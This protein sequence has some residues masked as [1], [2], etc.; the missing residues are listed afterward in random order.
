MDDWKLVEG[1]RFDG[2]FRLGKT[3]WRV[4]TNS[5]NRRHGQGTFAPAG[6]ANFGN[7]LS[8]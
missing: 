7:L 3:N 1:T 4:L 2:V 5:Q 6:K 8:S